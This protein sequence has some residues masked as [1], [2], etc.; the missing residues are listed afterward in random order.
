[1]LRLIP[2]GINGYF[3]SYGRQTMSFLVLTDTQALLLDAGTGL[4]RL[5][6]PTL[7]ELLEP[8]REL[9]ILLSHYHLDHVIGLSYL[10]GVWTRGRVRLFG[11]ASPFVEAE[12]AEALDRLLHPP[13]FSAGYRAFPGPVEIISVREK[14]LRIG[15]LDVRIWPQEHPGGSIGIRLGDEIAYV[16]DTVVDT[17]HVRFVSGVKLLAHE[18]W[19]T[20]EE[21]RAQGP[22]GHSNA[23]AVAEFARAAGVERLLLVHHQPKRTSDEIREMCETVEKL[24]G[25]PSPVPREGAIF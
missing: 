20:D 24:A 13:L 8:Y 5:I 2:L 11:P 22:K 23:S 10:P 4:S 7:R 19:F 6:E 9:D 15:D 3:P 1:M 25:I 21:A 14:T 17:E 18:L 12:P 16:T